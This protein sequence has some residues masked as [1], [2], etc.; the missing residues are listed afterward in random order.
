MARGGT[1]PAP[2]ASRRAACYIRQRPPP[3]FA[4]MPD[5]DPP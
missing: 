3:L 2:L 5:K 1:A 4:T